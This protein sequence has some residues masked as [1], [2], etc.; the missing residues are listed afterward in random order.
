MTVAGQ[1]F[2][3]MTLNC[4]RCHDHK[5]DP[6]PQTDY[7]RMLAFFREVRPHSYDQGPRSPSFT[8]VT[9][10]ERREATEKELPRR[11]DRLDE[12]TG[13]M[14]SIENESIKALP[15]E[16]QRAAEGPDRPKVVARVARALP[17]A[18]KAEYQELKRERTALEKRRPASQELALSV[19]N[20]DVRPLPVFVLARGNP[21]APGKEVAPGFPA[22]LGVPDPV[23]PAPRPGAKSSGRRTALAAWLTSKDNPLTA[24]VMVNRVWQNHFGRGLVPTAN[25]FGL[26]GEQPTHPELLDHLAADFVA[27]GWRVKRLHKQLM[28]SNAYRLSSRPD[29]AGL[30]ADPGNAL[31]GRFNMRRLAAEEVRDSIL[32]VSGGLDPALYGPSVYPRIPADVLAGQSVPG[33]GW[34]ASPPAAAN[35]R[36]VYVHVK[37]S[38][39]VPILATH[40]QADTDSSCP[41]RYTTTVP[42]QSLG[43]LNGEFANDRAAAFAARL[44]A[45]AP[46]DVRAQAA[47]GIR[48]TT[49]RAASADEAARDAAFVAALKADFRLDDATA[50]ARYALLLL[51]ANE[52]V[53]LD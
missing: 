38:L 21:H 5:V 49:G 16:D 3:G 25:D 6:I 50:L 42:T 31:L 4:A 39:Q 24:R 30:K 11:Q 17:A 40:D 19:N 2:L 20:C 48:L 26:L 36:S 13:R 52:F 23:V 18:R 1:G 51:N 34:P 43:L 53:Y 10:P 33:Q 45:E 32:A 14:A 35:R 44:R 41:V 37:R 29:A 8:D 9:P 12:L 15:A 27:G 22:V 28:M 46:S 47:R 7:Y